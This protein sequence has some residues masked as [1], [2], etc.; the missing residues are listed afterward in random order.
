MVEHLDDVDRG[1]LHVLQE[2]ARNA[3]AADM[4]DR[5]GV[6]ASTVRNRMAQLEEDGVI[7]GYYPEIDYERAGFDL[8]MFIIGRVRTADRHAVATEAVDLP[9]IVNVREL[10]TGDH[11][12]HFELVAV[13]SNAA[14]ET[15]A[16]LEDLGIE[17]ISTQVVKNLQVRPFD[18]FGVDLVE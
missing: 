15:I 9:G 3:T 10:M 1:I 4:G 7:Q 2:D 11:N 13:D 8:H 12:I 5:V 16:E 18:H 14:D 17:V 6:S